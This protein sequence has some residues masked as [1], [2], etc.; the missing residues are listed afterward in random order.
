MRKEKWLNTLFFETG[1]FEL[2]PLLGDEDRIIRKHLQ[3]RKTPEQ[4]AKE[5][6]IPVDEVRKIISAGIK[7]VLLPQKKFSQQKCGL[8]SWLVKGMLYNINW[9]H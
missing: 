8:V 1:L 5:E 6:E 7:K 9:Q 3:D 4:I 2:A